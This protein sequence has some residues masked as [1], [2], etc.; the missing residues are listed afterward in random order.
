MATLCART[1]VRLGVLCLRVSVRAL[2]DIPHTLE[3]IPDID[4]RLYNEGVGD[5]LARQFH[6]PSCCGP[7]VDTVVSS[8]LYGSL[9]LCACATLYNAI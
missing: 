6:S 3:N 9:S 8:W 2:Y 5:S 7:A 4:M 1:L